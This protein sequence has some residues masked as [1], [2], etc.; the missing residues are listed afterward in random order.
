[1]GARTGAAAIAVASAVLAVTLAAHHALSAVVALVALGLWIVIALIWPNAWLF[2]LPALLPILDLAPWTGSLF[3]DEFDLLILGAAFAGYTRLAAAPPIAPA[4]VTITRTSFVVARVRWLFVMLFLASLVASTWRGLAH[5][6]GFRGDALLLY[7]DPLNSLR[8]AKPYVF[9]LLLLPLTLARIRHSPKASSATFAAGMLVGLVMAAIS[10]VWER[11]AFPGLLDFSSDYRVTGTFWEMHVGGAALDGFLALTMPF[12]VYSLLRARSARGTAIAAMACAITFYASL[13]TFSRGLYVALVVA[14]P[15]QTILATWQRNREQR[16]IK[17]VSR[18]VWVTICLIAMVLEFEQ[19]FTYGGY[20]TLAALFGALG[21]SFVVSKILRVTSSRHVAYGVVAGLIATAASAWVGPLLFKGVY[22]LYTLALGICAVAAALPRPS[23]ARAVLAIA[24]YVC[25]AASVA[26]VARYWGGSVAFW[27]AGG[28]VIALITITALGGYTRVSLFPQ[29]PRAHVI[30]IGVAALLAGYVAVLTGGARMESRFATSEQ[31]FDE[32][33][34]HW[35]AGLS[36]LE[37]SGDWTFGKGLGRFPAAYRQHATRSH[38]PGRLALVHDAN[39]TIATMT[40]PGHMLGGGELLRLSQRVEVLSGQYLV[41]FD[42][43]SK[44][45]VSFAVEICEKHLLYV[46]EGHCAEAAVAAKA[47][48]GAVWSHLTAVLDGR[49]LT[50]GS[51]FAPR[52]AFFSIALTSGLRT[53][54]IDNLSVVDANGVELIQNGSFRDGF[55]RWFFTSDKYHLPWHMKNLA[56]AVLFDQGSIGAIALAVLIVASIVL[57]TRA[58]QAGSVVAPAFLAGLVAFMLVGMFDSLVD[59]P[60][61]AFLFYFLV[62]AG[63]ALANAAAVCAATDARSR[64]AWLVAA[65]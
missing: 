64:S 58:M 60:R 38:Y 19:V 28:P 4:A 33:I 9:A 55:D 62:L 30:A 12:A 63:P 23:P 27:D 17:Y 8:V 54:D 40:A 2:T 37:G 47:G 7:E 49:R 11:V 5:S 44:D 6:G 42:A 18:V 35:R 57:I 61:V 32:R 13:V 3:V 48:N 25:T 20:R 21:A 36:L 1:M 56:L 39:E 65:P 31:D 51:W 16:P 45:D 15:L 59:A 26:L 14:M 10:V 29:S 52:L 41:S 22:L 34:A 24:A 53:A 43:R 46:E 50:R